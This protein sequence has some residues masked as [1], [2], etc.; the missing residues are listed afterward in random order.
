MK[1][2]EIKVGNRSVYKWAKRATVPSQPRAQME[3]ESL[4]TKHLR[5]RSYNEIV[6]WLHQSG[7][8]LISNRI[9][10]SPFVWP[11][12]RNPDPL[13]LD[14]SLRIAF[15]DSW[16]GDYGTG[17][18]KYFKRITNTLE[19]STKLGDSAWPS[20]YFGFCSSRDFTVSIS[21]VLS[22]STLP[23]FTSFPRPRFL[24]SS[25]STSSFSHLSAPQFL[26]PSSTTPRAPFRAEI[27]TSFQFGFIPRLPRLLI[28]ST[29]I[30]I[31]FVS[32]T[33]TSSFSLLSSR[34][35]FVP[36]LVYHV[37]LFASDVRPR[38]FL[39]I[40]CF[41]LT[42]FCAL[43]FYLHF[44]LR[45]RPPFFAPFLFAPLFTRLASEYLLVIKVRNHPK[46]F[47]LAYLPTYFLR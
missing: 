14:R 31:S 43:I 23:L 17:L 34:F 45:F 11:R 5:P 38:L 15:I 36:I 12:R 20:P 21:F 6:S 3:Q 2:V 30:S 40:I 47:V 19:F 10:D 35:N 41:A 32:S 16:T 29:S 8:P 27:S 24:W 4:H 33:T 18:I 9:V 28:L 22:P 25:P 13:I 39:A 44:P 7:K 37:F 46:T 26:S 42:L 1:S